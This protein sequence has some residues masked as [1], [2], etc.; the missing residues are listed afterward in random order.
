M[1]AI[2]I[3]VYLVQQQKILKSRASSSPI[4]KAL[5]IKNQN[6]VLVCDSNQTIPTCNISDPE[7]T[8]KV[9][10]LDALISQ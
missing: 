1:T 10:D 9:I 5:E 4:L 3:G 8:I 2:P 7:V 6:D